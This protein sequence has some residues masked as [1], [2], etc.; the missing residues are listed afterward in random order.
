LNKVGFTSDKEIRRV[1]LEKI[2]AKPID[3]R[4]LAT[5]E[6]KPLEFIEKQI[7]K[8]FEKMI[9]CLKKDHSLIKLLKEMLKE[10]Y[11]NGISVIDALNIL[12]TYTE[13]I[14]EGPAVKG[15]HVLAYDIEKRIFKF[16]S[17]SMREATRRFIETNNK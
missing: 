6:M 12:D 9:T 14:A 11:K 4:N 2:G 13:K 8:D 7:Q 1:V 16:H 15:Y 3:L 10:E 17:N 5:S